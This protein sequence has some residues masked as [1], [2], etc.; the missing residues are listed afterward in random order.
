MVILV[1]VFAVEQLHAQVLDFRQR[2]DRAR[3]R[4]SFPGCWSSSRAVAEKQIRRSK[5][6]PTTG[7][8]LVAADCRDA[9]GGSGR[10]M[11]PRRWVGEHR[12]TAIF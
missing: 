2:Q 5:P 10:P 6:G 9:Q 11:P 1:V 12:Q 3:R 8:P 7:D 4:R